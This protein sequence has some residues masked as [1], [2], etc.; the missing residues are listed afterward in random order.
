MKKIFFVFTF[1]ALAYIYA[2]E[3]PNLGAVC[4]KY[5]A[6]ETYRAEQAGCIQTN[7]EIIDFYFDLYNDCTSSGGASAGGVYSC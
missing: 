4:A 5:A 2:K 1:L 3:Q 6:T 7:D